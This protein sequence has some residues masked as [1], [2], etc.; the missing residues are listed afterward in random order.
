LRL[1]FAVL[2]AEISCRDC[3]EALQR[4]RGCRSPAQIPSFRFENKDFFHCPRRELTPQTLVYFRFF[5]FF[6]EGFLPVEGGLLDQPAKFLEAMEVLSLEQSKYLRE[7][8]K[9]LWKFTK[10]ISGR[11]RTSPGGSRPSR[12]G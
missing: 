2:K 9:E 1:A 8:D 10:S 11:K 6:Q 4:A 12:L 3:N 7:E 5:N